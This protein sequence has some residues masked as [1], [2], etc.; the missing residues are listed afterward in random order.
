[1][2]QQTPQVSGQEYVFRATEQEALVLIPYCC[3]NATRTLEDASARRAM[4]ERQVHNSTPSGRQ[5]RSEYRYHTAVPTPQVH[6]KVMR[7]RDER[8]QS[9]SFLTAHFCYNQ[10]H[11]K[12]VH[13]R[14]PSGQQSRKR[15]KRA[16]SD[17]RASPAF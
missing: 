3:T 5:S 13:K 17:G 11:N 12:Q 14:M 16:T 4:T 7:A 15:S 8:W 1:M 6:R 2:H 10:Q 9:V